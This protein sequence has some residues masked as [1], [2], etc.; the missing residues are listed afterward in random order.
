MMRSVIW[1]Q[2]AKDRRVP[3]FLILLIA[4]SVLATII[5]TGGANSPSSFV[6][7]S[8]EAN[9]DQIEKKWEKLLNTDGS[10][11]FTIADSVLVK[12]DL[13]EGNI[14]SAVK[15]MENDYKIITSDE[16]TDVS[17]MQQHVHSVFQREAEISAITDLE[18]NELTRDDIEKY[19]QAGPVQMEKVGLNNEEMTDYNMRTQLMFAFTLLIATFILGFRV[20]NVTH[21]KVSGVWDRMI[22]A[23]ISK[24]KMYTGYIL[25][26][27]FISMFQ[28]VAVLLLFKYVLKYDLGNQFWLIILASAL[29]V[30]SMISIAML[31]TGFVKTP[32]QFYAI[33]PSI[34]PLI[35]LISGSYMMPGTISNPVLLFVADLFPMAHAMDAIM[36]VIFYDAG[37]A[38]ITMSLLIMLLIGIVGM[39]LGINLVERRSR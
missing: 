24:T 37:L 25:Y 23:P 15:L 11:E 13:E 39:G 17:Y 36:N 6:I 10:L 38:D 33:Y 20:N 18:G 7:Y 1:A 22:L 8:E 30:F 31:I 2:F 16:I 32:E 28:I 4:G 27:F 19:L 35:P 14:E 3:L 5:F 9:A 12:A 21:D 34:I 29:F 26:S